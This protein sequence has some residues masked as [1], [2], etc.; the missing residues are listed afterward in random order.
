M[1]LRQMRADGG[2]VTLVSCQAPAD[3]PPSRGSRAALSLHLR[4]IHVAVI[5]PGIRRTHCGNCFIA[6]RQLVTTERAA[7]LTVA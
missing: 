6:A 3:Y 2:G 1:R 5:R 7:L 4:W